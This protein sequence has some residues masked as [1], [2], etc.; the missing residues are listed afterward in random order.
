METHNHIKF[1]GF[2]KIALQRGYKVGK[3]GIFYGATGKRLKKVNRQGYKWASIQINGKNKSLY[4]HRLQAYQKYNNE[5]YDK[6]IVVRHLDGN[7]LNNSWD[8][9]AIGTSSDNSMD[10]P[11]DV[12][13]AI[14][15]KG[16]QAVIKYNRKEVTKYYLDSGRSQKKTKERFGIS[17]N[18]T[19]R[20]ILN[21][22]KFD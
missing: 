19:L 6:G 15:S 3:D 14:A 5:I 18:S 9:I 21:E 2:E 10:V 1:S 12:R 22:R 4:A 20:Y 7:K 13:V 8:N 11:K 16:G 17:S